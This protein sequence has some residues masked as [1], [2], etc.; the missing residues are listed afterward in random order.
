MPRFAQN[1][2]LVRLLL[3]NS[4]TIFRISAS[5]SR[6]L[7]HALFCRLARRLL[8]DGFLGR[9]PMTA[10]SV[11]SGFVELSLDHNSDLGDIQLMK[12]PTVDIGDFGTLPTGASSPRPS[13]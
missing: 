6:L 1:S 8:Q 4:P 9:L 10:T 11:A 12:A 13:L 7:P 3:E 5:T 2:R